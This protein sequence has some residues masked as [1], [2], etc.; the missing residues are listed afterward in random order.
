MQLQE[1][2]Y[3]TLSRI[4]NTWW[5]GG[6]LLAA[7]G[8]KLGLLLAGVVPFNSDEAVVALMA[9]HILQGEWPVFFYGQAYMGS[10]DAF[11]VAASFALFGQHIW[12][13]RLVQGLLYLGVLWTTCLLG[14][15]LLGS[16]RLGLLAVWL[17]AIP[18]VVMTLY[19]TASLGGYGEALLLGNLLLLVGFSLTETRESP[20]WH[21]ALW[22]WL[23]GLG[24]WAFG[25]TLVYAVPAGLML[26][27]ELW[28][29][30]WRERVRALVLMALGGLVG[31]APWW[32]YALA[33]GWAILLR[34]LA[35]GGIA[36]V[37]RG[38]WLVNTWTHFWSF[39]LFGGTAVFGVRPP[40]AVRW[41]G[42]P[43]L[44]L[45]LAFWTG[46]VV[47]LLTRL[48]TSASYRRGA[49]LLIGVM[50]TLAL[51]F[52]FTS[53]GADPSGRYFLPLI[54][55]LAL[56]AAEA[57]LEL[58]V[59]YG[60]GVLGLAALVLV[61]NFWGTVQSARAYPPGITTQFDAVAQVDHRYM[62]ELMAFLA[63]HGET[64]GYTNYWV[65]YPLAFLSQEK[66]VFV[67][68]LPYHQDFRYTPRDDRYPPYG[69]LVAAS[70]R[71]AYITTNHPALD[72]RLREGFR[73]LGV[74][75]SEKQIGDYHVFYGLSRVVR[76][77][78]LGVGQE[79]LIALSSLDGLECEKFGARAGR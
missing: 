30:A 9:R 18:P 64:R 69:E 7:A 46:V 42:L 23:A 21:W 45:A 3:H 28:R 70:E 38:H 74:D 26:L 4:P 61:Y 71:V 62:P 11:L 50:I 48:R 79:G 63:E 77:E 41:L 52:I 73:S 27:L 72:A 19:T 59:R 12:V 16:R 53:F 51:S 34:E 20:A 10:L 56:F 65:A 75:F 43:L 76:P 67:P 29:R 8:L 40:W 37:E 68:R 31:A 55:P 58:S 1:R 15:R 39:F 60:R 6:A 54:V 35:G 78:E 57:L 22:G 33:N 66:L 49:T 44:P 47:Y 13:I 25:L 14:A 2:Y 17:L 5:F 24:L 32:G 36:G